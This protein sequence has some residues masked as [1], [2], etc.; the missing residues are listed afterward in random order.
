MANLTLT[1]NPVS[2]K[3]SVV[4]ILI[5]L[6]I[7]SLALSLGI[8]VSLMYTHGKEVKLFPYPPIST[9]GPFS[10]TLTPE[11]PNST[12]KIDYYS[13]YDPLD[14]LFGVT[15]RLIGYFEADGNISFQIN[16]VGNPPE[17][18][19]IFSVSNVSNFNF[20]VGGKTDYIGF[21]AWELLIQTESTYPVN[22]TIHY[23]QEIHSFA[24]FLVGQRE[25][26]ISAAQLH[27]YNDSCLMFI[28]YESA[29]FF[30]SVVGGFLLTVYSLGGTQNLQ[31]LNI[32]YVLIIFGG[33]TAL[34]SAF[35][36]VSRLKTKKGGDKKITQ[37]I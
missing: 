12:F 7:G 36:T 14:S 17:E 19:P 28:Y 23:Y 30:V 18:N 4:V 11:N 8:Y 13:L 10:G 34:A 3:K 25:I 31:I 37:L 32:S 16:L 29:L 2:S 1:S 22:F 21:D 9:G 24:N 6:L 35:E 27:V 5:L 15:P 26:V 20:S 33:A